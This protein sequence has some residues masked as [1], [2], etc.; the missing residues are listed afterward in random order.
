MEHARL[1]VQRSRAASSQQ[2]IPNTGGTQLRSWRQRAIAAFATTLRITLVSPR[3]LGGCPGSLD[4]D[5]SPGTSTRTSPYTEYRSLASYKKFDRASLVIE[6]AF[7]YRPKRCSMAQELAGLRTHSQLGAVGK[8]KPDEVAGVDTALRTGL[9]RPVC[10]V[11]SAEVGLVG[12]ELG[13]SPSHRSRVPRMCPGTD[14]K[15]TGPGPSDHQGLGC[16]NDNH[17][18]EVVTISTPLHCHKLPLTA[19]EL[20]AVNHVLDKFYTEN[21]ETWNVDEAVAEL[22]QMGIPTAERATFVLLWS[23]SARYGSMHGTAQLAVM[24]D[25][26]RGGVPIG[27]IVA[28]M[29]RPGSATNDEV[30]KCLTYFNRLL[31]S[32]D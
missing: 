27:E 2:V 12:S 20:E 8:N 11:R 17:G 1:S 29:E 32:H 25:H 28:E 22:L 3:G 21:A 18:G 19:G 15:P 31:P 16:H 24:I 4:L 7:R 14:R 26:Y 5:R 30:W 13:L 9:R 10:A 6:F 23:L